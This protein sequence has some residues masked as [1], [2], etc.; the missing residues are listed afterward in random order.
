MSPKKPP[1]LWDY[2]LSQKEFRQIL[3]GDLTRGRLDQDWAACRLIE[4][5]SYEE[6][7]QELGFRRLV[8]NW[9]HWRKNIRSKSRLRG[10]D[11]VVEWLPQKHPEKLNG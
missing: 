4:Y 8:E 1:Y 6:I 3:A 5:A 9:S 10:F 2:D 11:F 7:I